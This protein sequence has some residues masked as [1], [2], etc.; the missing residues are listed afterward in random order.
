MVDKIAGGPLVQAEDVPEEAAP[1]PQDKRLA[2]ATL[3]GLANAEVDAEGV[4]QSLGDA[5]PFTYRIEREALVL[6]NDDASVVIGWGLVKAF[7][8]A[9]GELDARENTRL[10]WRYRDEQG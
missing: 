3:I 10:A 5:L 7:R 9:L 2:N 1:V 8:A 4:V 6:R